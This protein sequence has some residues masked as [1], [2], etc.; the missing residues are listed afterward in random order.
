MEKLNALVLLWR[1][2]IVWRLVM[3]I[4]D[5]GLMFDNNLLKGFR[6]YCKAEI[7]KLILKVEVKLMVKKF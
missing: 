4:F 1:Q 6:K 5:L 7:F 3:I 2:I